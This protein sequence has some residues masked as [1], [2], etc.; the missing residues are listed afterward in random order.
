MIIM[1]LMTQCCIAVAKKY[2][3]TFGLWLLSDPSD[4]IDGISE[5]RTT[6]T[7]MESTSEV[8]QWNSLG[9]QNPTIT[10]SSLELRMPMKNEDDKTFVICQQL[11]S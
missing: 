6:V 10:L 7:E 8:G 9:S 4:Q 1:G 11:V 2:Y 3:E 5:E